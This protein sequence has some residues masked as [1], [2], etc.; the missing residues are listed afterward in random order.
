[1]KARELSFQTGQ[2][3]PEP[4]LYL[5][6]PNQAKSDFSTSDLVK[7]YQEAS[8]LKLASEP[9]GTSIDRITISQEASTLSRS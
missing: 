2:K 6:N 4:D 5:L 9:F 3:L 1:L 7:K 8:L